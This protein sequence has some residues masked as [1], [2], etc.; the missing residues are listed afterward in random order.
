MCLPVYKEEFGHMQQDFLAK[1]FI[2]G[3]IQIFR[4]NHQIKLV[5]SC[6]QNRCFRNVDV[7]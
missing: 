7:L 6:P 5:L 3:Q 4:L 1:L 2:F